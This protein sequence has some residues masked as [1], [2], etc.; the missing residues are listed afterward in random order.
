MSVEPTSDLAFTSDGSAIT[1]IETP[2]AGSTGLTE[3]T[4]TAPSLGSG[5]IAVQRTDSRG[6]A[7]HGR[8]DR[9]KGAS[10][11]EEGSK[12]GRNP[13][14]RRGNG[15][16]AFSDVAI[17]STARQPGCLLMQGFQVRHGFLDAKRIGR[18]SSRA[19]G[20]EIG[21]RSSRESV[22][23]SLRLRLRLF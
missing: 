21:R 19:Y 23:L 15:C 2:D 1:P 6:Q 9:P 7:G 3:N 16:I 14:R 22:R 18:A 12:T 13:T 11:R 17:G 10:I 8:E 4:G 20:G 5:T